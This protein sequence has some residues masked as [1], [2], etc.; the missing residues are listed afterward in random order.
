MR[1][2]TGPQ[3][4]A[5]AQRLSSFYGCSVDRV[6][7]LS[8]EVRPA[9]RTRAD[10]GTRAVCI[11][12]NDTLR[13][14]AELVTRSN[15]PPELALEMAEL[16]SG[17][18]V[19]VSL[20]TFRRQLRE[21]GLN[22]KRMRSR[23]RAFRPFEADSPMDIYQFDISGVKERWVDVRTRRLFQVTAL[24][25]SRNHPYEHPTRV[26]LWKFSLL[27][28][29]SRRRFVRFIACAKPNATHCIEFL[30]D[31][32]REMGIPRMFYTDRDRIIVGERMSRAAQIL[33]RLFEDDGG[34]RMEQ[35]RAGNPQATGKVERTHQVVEQYEPLIGLFEEAVGEAG[36]TL[37]RLNDFAREICDRL[38]WK[39]HRKT[40]EAPML[41]WQRASTAQR[42][43]PPAVLDAIFT[44]DEFTVPVAADVTVG[45]EGKRFQLPRRAEFP[46]AE[47]ASTGR[48]VKVIRMKGADSFFV[49][50]DDGSVFEVAMVEARPDSAG[51]F[52][53]LPETKRDRA[54]KD[55]D[56][57]AKER[58]RRHKEEGTRVLVPGFDASFKKQGARAGLMPKR[59][60]EADTS[61]LAEI[62]PAAAAFVEGR[63][64]NRWQ[65]LD[66][67][68]QLRQ[69]DSETPIHSA[70]KAWLLTLFGERE[71]MLDTE[72]RTA[73]DARPAER[74][75][76]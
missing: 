62:A 43:P 20:A 69:L 64:I 37:D 48:K 39:V 12:E 74:K 41:R 73:F 5:E 63:P 25:D 36:A 55:L 54:L 6:Y 8:R 24:E 70:D 18:E 75:R 1:G 50:Q 58:K 46:F 11:F 17:V 35:H 60:K 14:A 30:L 66:L 28:D 16:T 44:A 10:K 7:S 34:F 65:A 4:A 47:Y 3:A 29:C 72:I 15:L 38:N 45:F 53:S 42:I 49:A 26:K 67:L 27:D 71:E 13:H 21:F 33:N 68:R 23:R 19:A 59:R 52:K 56:A 2:L 31:A 51:E 76:A 32:C 40:G 57:S 22:R 9:R 61:R